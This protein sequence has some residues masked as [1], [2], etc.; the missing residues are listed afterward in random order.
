MPDESFPQLASEVLA[1]L[2]ELFQHQ[3]KK[4]LA[5]VFKSARAEFVEIEYDN[6]NGGTYTWSLKIEV[7]VSAFAG[8]ASRLA[9]V[10]K[11]CS[12]T[13]QYLDQLHPNHNLSGVTITPLSSTVLGPKQ[14]AEAAMHDREVMDRIWGNGAVR[15]FLSHRAEFKVQTAE[16]Q[17]ALALFCG[18]SSFVAHE[19]I[20]PTEEWM[21]EIERALFSMDV[22]VALLSEDFPDS[23]WTDQEVGVAIGRE[24]PLIAIRLGRDPYG[25][26]GQWQGVGGCSWDKPQEMA[27][28]ILEILHKK[29]ADKSKLFEAALSAYASSESFDSSGWAIEN[30]LSK[31]KTLTSEQVG[32]VMESYRENLQNMHSFKGRGLLVPL[33]KKWTGEKWV[34]QNEDLVP[35]SELHSTSE[36]MPF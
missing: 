30:L 10:E 19:D 27:M 29:L 5:N 15:V 8:I 34:L 20:H 9:D 3:D 12:T 2:V 33:L 31:F 11:E 22:M 16:L 23:D 4:E 25:L 6:W 18:I 24:V 14:A 13:L 1:T 21:R 28:K 17:K 7:P 36:N 26:M 35:E 32:R